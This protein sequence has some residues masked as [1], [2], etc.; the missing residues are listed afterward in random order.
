ML[1]GPWGSAAFFR[2]E[3]VP[4]HSWLNSY[5][6]CWL[7]CGLNACMLSCFSRVRLIVTLWTVACRAPL[8]MGFSRQS[9]G[10]GC[11]A[12]LQGIFLIQGL[13]PSLLHFLQWPAGSLPPAA[14]PN[15]GP[16]LLLERVMP[17]TQPQEGSLGS[18][19]WGG[20]RSCRVGGSEVTAAAL[21]A[22]P[23]ASAEVPGPAPGPATHQ[24]G[25]LVRA[26]AGEDEGRLLR[27]DGH[28]GR[29]RQAQLHDARIEAPQCS[30]VVQADARGVAPAWGE[31]GR[32]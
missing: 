6:Q 14:P 24:L 15:G 25:A 2:G 18:G 23:W 13:N 28:H 27:G 19:G 20:C 32:R 17:N 9:T 31:E 21:G 30:R 11:H 8:S 10:V 16:Q 4:A 29:V 12:F 1:R 7:G 3:R 26:V 22:H 5:F